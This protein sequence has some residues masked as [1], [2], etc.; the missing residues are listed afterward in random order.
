MLDTE[1]KLA[2][3]S[4]NTPLS[5]ILFLSTYTHIMVLLLFVTHKKISHRYQ[6]FM[7]NVS[8]ALA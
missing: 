2:D 7:L 4:G 5:L 1:I 6:Y 8:T 3:V